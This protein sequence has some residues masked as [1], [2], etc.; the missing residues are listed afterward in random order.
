MST[1]RAVLFDIINA[2]GS[3][4]STSE[5]IGSR[6]KENQLVQVKKI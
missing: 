3:I 2:C 4:E 6:L 5:M 1:G